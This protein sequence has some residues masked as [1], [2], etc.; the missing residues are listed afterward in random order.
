M[1]ITFKDVEYLYQKGTPF[2]RRAIYDINLSIKS[3][4]FLSVIGHTGSGKSTL[5]Q[6]INGLI[7]PSNGEIHVGKFTINSRKKA[8]DLKQLRRR[9]GIVFQYPEH[10]LFEETVEK[11]IIFAPINFGVTEKNAIKRA[12]EAIKSVGLSEDV[13]QKS[14]FDLSGGQKRRVAIAGVL[15]MNPEVMILDEPTAGLD[16]RG[17]REI[18]TMF[19]KLHE[20]KNLTTILVTH[21]MDNAAEFSDEIIVMHEG[22]THLR[23]T[24]RE[25]FRNPEKLKEIGLDVPESVHF[26]KKLEQKIGTEL[27]Y[28][29]FT[30]KDTVN[31]VKTVFERGERQ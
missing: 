29:V 2:E 23:G 31:V 8:K 17:R 15:V 28:D 14:P 16:P 11:D 18:L 19:K 10:Q 3:G 20:E 30:V 12:K 6:H 25:V 21:S 7:K 26:I 22:T 1:E 9:V 13:L 4:T 5:M 24:P 27:P